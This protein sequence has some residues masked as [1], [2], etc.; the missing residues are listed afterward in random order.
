MFLKDKE[1]KEY[2]KIIKSDRSVCYDKEAI[3]D[4]EVI[5]DKEVENVNTVDF[6]ARLKQILYQAKILFYKFAR[7]SI[8]I[9]V[10]LFI[11]QSVGLLSSFYCLFCL[12][13]IYKEN[14]LK[15]IKEDTKNSEKGKA[16]ELRK[17]MSNNFKNLE[18]LD[19]AIKD[20][21][22]NDLEKPL[23][24]KN[25]KKVKFEN[26]EVIKEEN[27]KKDNFLYRIDSYKNFLGWFIRL[28][29]FDITLQIII[30]I[31]LEPT[32]IDQDN[33]YISLGLYKLWQFSEENVQP[34]ADHRY[35]SIMF[36]IY[37]LAILLLVQTMMSSEDFRENHV[38]QCEN[39]ENQSK[40]I[41]YKMS[42]EFNTNRLYMSTLFK[43]SKEAFENKLKLLEENIRYLNIKIYGNS[44]TLERRKTS[45]SFKRA[46][47]IAKLKKKITNYETSEVLENNKRVLDYL[48]Q[49]INP[50][51]FQYYI[52][53]ITVISSDLSDRKKI[54]RDQAKNS[55]LKKKF[56]E[57][58]DENES[59]NS[60]ESL[61]QEE[62]DDADH[63]IEEKDMKSQNIKQKH[64][65]IRTEYDLNFKD[66]PELIAYIFASNVETMVYFMFFLNHFM[67]ASLES[68][69]FPL[70]LLGYAMLEYPRPRVR[71]FRI[72]LIYTEIV[73]FIK[74][75]LQLEISKVIL[76]LSPSYKDP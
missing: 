54:L 53:K 20:Q 25:D 2:N 1:L 4:K 46:Q 14:S 45:K 41:A 9:I 28:V 29:A 24:L 67:Y 19:E 52:E 76:G 18:L 5:N 63:I 58:E 44:E 51:L 68:L 32:S 61:H 10:L 43:K 16:E 15:V 38:S 70:S 66:Y 17:S 75:T 69:V 31:P 73:F 11:T 7:F 30:Q 23:L 49:L 26:S 50:S 21:D 60:D 13:F 35:A 47:T 8:V 27:N 42:S 36:K 62:D 64:M 40:N 72:M 55:K 37:T 34:D 6:K 65:D 39:I 56:Y 3:T 12:F 57:S 74:F 59:L 71:F 33:Y 48:I 22:K